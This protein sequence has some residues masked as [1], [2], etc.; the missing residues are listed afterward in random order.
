MNLSGKGWGAR[1]LLPVLRRLSREPGAGH[2]FAQAAFSQEIL[3]E[4]SELLVQEVVSL[5]D[6]ADEDVSYARESNDC[7]PLKKC[8][9]DFGHCGN[10]GAITQCHPRTVMVQFCCW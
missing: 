10:D 6:E 2:P 3:F 1:S 5:V 9:W 7:Q 8:S 4:T